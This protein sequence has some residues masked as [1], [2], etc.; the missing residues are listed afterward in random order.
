MRAPAPRLVAAVALAV[1][2]GLGGPARALDRGVSLG[3][4][5]ED[6]GWSY[7]PLLDEIRALGADHVELVVAWYQ[8][9]VA[10]TGIY[11]HPRFTAPDEAVRRAIRDARAAGL[12]VLLFPIVRLESPASPKEWRGTLRPSDRAAWFESYRARLIAL[13]RLG[14]KEG[15]TGLSV[16]SELSTLDGPDAHAEWARTIR[17]VRRVFSGALTY[18]GNWDHFRQVALYDL[19]DQIGLCA[20]WPLAPAGAID[21][22]VDDLVR[23]WRDLRVSL[24]RFA[25]ARHRPL[26]FTEVGYLSQRGAAAW[27]Y[28]EG[29]TQPVD[30]EEQRRAYEAFRRVWQTAPAG[31]VAGIYFWNWYGWGGATSRGYT[32]RGKPAAEEIRKLY[33]SVT[34][35]AVDER[36]GQI[37]RR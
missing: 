20:Y 24:E 2:I 31:L 8:K 26:I 21:S 22:S 13:A 17:A 23:A 25:R 34:R 32:P 4:F 6:P 1:F 36:P 35:P 37:G 30:L 7:R 15:A 27:P 5:A 28:D 9:G 12:K 18:S 10:S 16:G 33:R 19:V 29:A 14:E 3:L 11:S